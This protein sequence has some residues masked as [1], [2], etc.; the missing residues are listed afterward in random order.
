MA[1]ALSATLPDSALPGRTPAGLKFRLWVMMFLQYFVQGAYLPVLTV[2]LDTGLG[3]GPEQLGYVGAAIAVG[4]L[5]A[6]FFVGQ[7]V[8]RHFATDRVL[9]AFHLGCGALML[10]LYMLTSFWPI[11]VVATL[12]SALYVPT[13]MLTNSLSFWHLRDREREFPAVRLWGTVG[14]IVPAFFIEMVLLRGMGGETLDKARGVILLVSGIGSLAMAAYCLLLPHTPP[15]KKKHSDFA[16]KKVFELLRLVDFRVLVLVSFVV[17]IAHQY[18]F[19]W[20]SPFLQAMLRRGGIERALEQQIAAIGQIFEVAV[21]AVLGLMLRRLGFKRTL[22]IGAAAYAVRCLVLGT[23]ASWDGPFPAVMTLVGVGQALHGVC[24]GC[25]L[26]VAFIYVDRVAPV[27]IRGS[28]Q[29]L[30]GV[31]VISLGLSLGALVS[32]KVGAAFTSDS[33]AAGL[34]SRMGIEYTV[35]ITTEEE[36]TSEGRVT[37]H[38]DWPGI[39]FSGAV[40]AAVAVGW[41]AI[42]FPRDPPPANVYDDGTNQKPRA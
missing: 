1:D 26:A 5:V 10:V 39:W 42:S 9:A 15:V 30:Y 37:R 21:M 18:F 23:A 24:F 16:P 12:Y 4:S 7:L 36:R 41:L 20:N 31:V 11:L 33:P 29:N 35:G 2:Y 32:G 17:A 34:R 3:F 28:V 40:I 14:F 22:L 38:R 19:V 13:T 27:D 8:D 6:P 25:F